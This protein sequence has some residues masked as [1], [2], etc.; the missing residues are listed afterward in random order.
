MVD[1]QLDY[2]SLVNPIVHPRHLEA[3]TNEYSPSQTTEIRPLTSRNP[4]SIRREAD[5]LCRPSSEFRCG[6]AI[7]IKVDI[8]FDVRTHERS[9]TVIRN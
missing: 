3:I 5:E 9:R 8:N 6:H 7:M 4:L 1:S 2:L